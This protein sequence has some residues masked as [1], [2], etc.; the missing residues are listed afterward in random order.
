MKVLVVCN[1]FPYNDLT[2]SGMA[3]VE[4][5]ATPDEAS[6]KETWVVGDSNS[7]PLALQLALPLG[8]DVVLAGE[9]DEEFTKNTYFTVDV[10]TGET[11]AKF[12]A[13]PQF[14]KIAFDSMTGLLLVPADTE[15]VKRFMVSDSG[16]T[17]L[18]PIFFGRGA[19]PTFGIWAL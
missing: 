18:D 3:I 14:G 11:S 2:T 7:N 15:G 12:N 9:P 19:L 5:G 17:E 8:G 16:F 1:G 6:V 4:I 10:A 13:P